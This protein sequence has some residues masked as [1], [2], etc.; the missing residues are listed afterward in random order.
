[1]RHLR[2][3]R[4]ALAGAVLCATP[5]AL[6]TDV[7]SEFSILKKRLRRLPMEGGAMLAVRLP[8][9]DGTYRLFDVSDSRTLPAE[10]AARFPRLRSFR[11]TDA[12]GRT[13]RLDLS[14]S[15]LRMSVRHGA[16]EFTLRAG[17]AAEW[18]AASNPSAS[19]F[20]TGTA[21]YPMTSGA[22]HGPVDIDVRGGAQESGLVARQALSSASTHRGGSVRYDFRLAVATSSRFAARFGGSVEGTLA[23][24]AHAVNR[25]NE[26]FETDVGAHF[27]LVAGNDR[28]IRTRPSR[29]PFLR[30]DPAPAAVAL[31]D[32]EIG[33]THY[34]I[35]HALTDYTGG[36]SDIGTSCSDARDADF[37]ATHKAA[38]WSGHGDPRNDTDAMG[39]MIHV[40]GRQLGAWPTASGCPRDTLEDRAFEPGSGTTAMGYAPSSCGRTPRWQ[41]HTDRYFHAANIEQMQDWLASRGGRCAS[42]HINT[43]IAPWI[44]PRTFAARTTLPART[45]FSLDANAEPGTPGRILSYTWEQMDTGSGEAGLLPAVDGPLFRSWAPS[46]T[47]RREFPR[48]GTLRDVGESPPGETLPDTSRSL[49]FRITVRDNGGRDATIAHADARLDVFDTGRPFALRD[50]LPPSVPAGSHLIAHWDVA[51]TDRPPI[52]CHFVMIDLSLDD[53][54]TWEEPAL[55]TDEPNDGEARLMLPRQAASKRARLRARCDRRPFFAV[56]PRAFAIKSAA[57]D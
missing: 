11:G 48:T 14:R 8:I 55:A 27:T 15:A 2:F 32:R 45:P 3:A 18:L 43:S 37:L 26:V 4:A 44:D 50:T 57:S 36:E 49:N 53:G 35:G 56:S 1:M 22:A 46:S 47:G 24:V 13:L 7:A 34:D 25:A 41:A 9:G 16:S 38:A 39:F 12:E 33:A 5:I 40:L 54:A 23:E 30:E 20:P 6:A 21:F 42:R 17:T 51:E 29:D 31:I 28:L 10:L 19:P 52:S